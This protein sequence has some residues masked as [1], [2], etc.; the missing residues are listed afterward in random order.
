M[1]PAWTDIG[2]APSERHAQARD[3][4]PRPVTFAGAPLIVTAISQITSG[5]SASSHSRLHTA[6]FT[7]LGT[8]RPRPD[9]SRQLPV[10]T[11]RRLEQKSR[12]RD[13]VG[14]IAE[15]ER[16]RPRPLVRSQARFWPRHIR[17]LSLRRRDATRSGWLSE[18]S[19]DPEVNHAAPHTRFCGG[20]GLGISAG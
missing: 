11:G 10:P 4:N 5:I 18:W 7:N 13:P 14:D 1:S 15:A 8:C 16:A 6:A 9:G 3:A 20:E 12:R 17:R 19:S 2:E